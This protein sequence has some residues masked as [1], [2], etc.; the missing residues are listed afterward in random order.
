MNWNVKSLIYKQALNFFT[1]ARCLTRIVV[2]AHFQLCIRDVIDLTF[3]TGDL[4]R[5]QN[6]RP[7]SNSYEH[8]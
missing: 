2:G 4:F 5:K 7:T 8:V 6:I 3:V 1:S